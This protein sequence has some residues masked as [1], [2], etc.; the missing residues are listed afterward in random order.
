MV[1]L[2]K[3][4]EIERLASQAIDLPIV[5]I[6]L[7]IPEAEQTDPLVRQAFSKGR[8]IGLEKVT[9]HLV[10]AASRGNIAAAKAL[11][12]RLEAE[13]PK[14]EMQPVVVDLG[15]TDSALAAMEYQRRLLDGEIE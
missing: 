11:S 5:L 2:E 7:G 8:S 4:A 3:L 13:E 10:R 14:A 6:Y 9:G 1:E 15:T 12:A